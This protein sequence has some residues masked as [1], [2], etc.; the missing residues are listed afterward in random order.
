MNYSNTLIPGIQ[1][2]FSTMGVNVILFVN[3]RSFI[4]QIGF[5]VFRGVERG[6][7]DDP[8]NVWKPTLGDW[9]MPCVFSR[10]ISPVCTVFAKSGTCNPQLVVCS[11]EGK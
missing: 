1:S 11:V 4:I 7:G 5:M 10:Q 9:P 6:S 3:L 8:K 2:A